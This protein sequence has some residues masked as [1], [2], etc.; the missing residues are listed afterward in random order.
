MNQIEAPASRTPSPL[1]GG[2]VGDGGVAARIGGRPWFGAEHGLRPNAAALTSTPAPP[3]SRGRGRDAWTNILAAFITLF[4]ALTALPAFATPTFPPLAGQR[5]VD[6]AHVLSSQT[7][8]DLTAKLA[9]LEAKTGHQLVVATISDLQGDDIDDYGYQLGRAWGIGQKGTN[10]GVIL[11]IAPKEHKVRIEVGYGLEATITDALSSVILQEQ[12]LPKLRTGDMDGAVTAGTDALITQLSLD[13]A[14]A[15]ARAA[16][17]VPAT[18][19]GQNPIGGIFGV[20]IFFIVLSMLFRGARGGGMG[21]LLP[22]MILGSGG[23]G[24]WGGGSG[25][26]F[27]GGGGFSGGGGSFGGGG[28]SGSW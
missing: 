10:D 4:V 27:G 15:Q 11:I 25:G 17:A 2:R 12:V 7:V 28:A 14:T 22:M 24:G 21:W 5:V 19:P 20:I 3:P 23:R 9:A 6:D 8:A 1:D 13:P 16:A 18:H 26:G